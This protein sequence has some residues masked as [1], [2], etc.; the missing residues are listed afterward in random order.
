MSQAYYPPQFSSN[1]NQEYIQALVSKEVRKYQDQGRVQNAI[2]NPKTKRIHVTTENPKEVES[3]MWNRWPL[4]SNYG[5][6]QRYK[7]KNAA[8][9]RHANDDQ[10]QYNFIAPEFQDQ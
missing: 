1:N 7:A 5:E 10:A 6:Y 9:E 4:V 2:Y 8:G 3:E